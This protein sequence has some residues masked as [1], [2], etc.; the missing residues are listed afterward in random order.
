[1]PVHLHVPLHLELCIIDTGARISIVLHPSALNSCQIFSPSVKPPLR[2]F[3]Y[4]AIS[5]ELHL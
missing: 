5:L 3:T 4:E 2:S 1:M